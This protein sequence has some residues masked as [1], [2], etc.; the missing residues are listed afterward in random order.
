MIHGVNLPFVLFRTS[1]RLNITFLFFHKAVQMSK[2]LFNT[3]VDT[4]IDMM[5]LLED[6]E[7]DEEYMLLV[8]QWCGVG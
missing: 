1:S 8:W 5:L 6:E 4:T 3:T 7:D 2:R